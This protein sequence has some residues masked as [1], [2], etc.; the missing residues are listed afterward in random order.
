MAISTVG[1]AIGLFVLA[2]VGLGSASYNPDEVENLSA[3]LWRLC[4]CYRRSLEAQEQALLC[5]GCSRNRGRRKRCEGSVAVGRTW[6]KGEA[7]D[8][9]KRLEEGSELSLDYGKLRKA[10]QTS[11]SVLPVAVQDVD[12]KELLIL[13]YANEQ[14]VQYTVEHGVA[15]FWSTSRDE[16][17]VKGATSGDT[18]EDGRDSC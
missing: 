7:I 1:S 11:A 9:H 4:G 15:A 14:A 12:T 18:L 8:S 5:C 10:A 6:S 16:L 3:E 13:A 2:G 17:W